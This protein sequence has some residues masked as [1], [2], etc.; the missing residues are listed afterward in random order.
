[1]NQGESN[2]SRELDALSLINHS[3][4][5]PAEFGPQAGRIV[6]EMVSKA[7]AMSQPMSCHPAR[8]EQVELPHDLERRE[9]MMKAASVLVDVGFK[10]PL[11]LAQRLEKLA[12]NGA[13]RQYS[14][15][16]WR[17]MSG[18]DSTLEE[19][20]DW[21]AIYAELDTLRATWDGST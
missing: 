7:L 8:L 15:A 17:L 5:S 12:P 2:A 20:P 6:D 14:R 1:M 9:A 3:G 21:H 4:S 10:T 18:F 13:L 11:E 19:S 16:F